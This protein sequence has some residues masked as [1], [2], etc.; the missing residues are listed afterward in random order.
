MAQPLT[1]SEQRA[2]ARMGHDWIAAHVSGKPD[3]AWRTA[4]EY[5]EVVAAVETTADRA[6]REFAA[7]ERRHQLERATLRAKHE[8]RS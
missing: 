2:L 3:G 6:A 1:V 7:L 8:G 5:R 4:P